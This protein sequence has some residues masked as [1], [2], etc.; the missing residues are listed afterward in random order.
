[1]S[2]SDFPRVSIYFDFYG[3][4]DPVE[5]TKRLGI[6]PTRQFRSGEPGPSGVGHRRRDGWI[7]AVGPATTFEIDDLLKQMR[8]AVTVSP[9]DIKKV[10]FEL[11]I[12]PA[13][14][15]EVQSIDSMPSLCF[16]G[17]FVQW[18]ASMGAAID[19][20]IMLLEKSED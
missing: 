18:V 10:S 17:E 6:E 13:V 19:V 7:V 11:N 2:P 5:I 3:V 20:D 16:P 8:A 9:E 15:C 12:K 1:V 14:T 4:F